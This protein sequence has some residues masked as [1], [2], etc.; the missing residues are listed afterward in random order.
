[1][2]HDQSPV[3]PPSNRRLTVT[4]TDRTPLHWIPPGRRWSSPLAHPDEQTMWRAIQME[5]WADTP[6]LVYADWLDDQGDGPAATYVRRLVRCSPEEW[7]GRSEPD[8]P[9]SWFGRMEIT[10]SPD[11]GDRRVRERAWRACR[12]AAHDGLLVDYETMCA[13][14]LERRDRMRYLLDEQVEWDER[15]RNNPPRGRGA[16]TIEEIAQL[17]AAA[18]PY[19]AARRMG[20]GHADA[21][22]VHFL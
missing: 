5:P 6:R 15:D 4:L 20:L 21:S 13:Y 17:R 12:R 22:L 10:L 19:R 16:I 1:M 14:L 2:C 7:L 18:S 11:T 8:R 3:H 9:W